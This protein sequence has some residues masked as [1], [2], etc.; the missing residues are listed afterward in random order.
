MGKKKLVKE[1]FNIRKITVI[2]QNMCNSFIVMPSNI[3]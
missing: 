2:R 1:I 3:P